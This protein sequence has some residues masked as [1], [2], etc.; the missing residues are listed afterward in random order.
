M[1]APKGVSRLGHPEG[2]RREQVLD[3]G[4]LLDEPLLLRVPQER[5]EGRPI[6]LYAI[7]SEIVAH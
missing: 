2:A 4:P 3:G 6:R 5:L 1:G 7:R